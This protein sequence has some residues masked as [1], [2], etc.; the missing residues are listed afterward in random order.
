[1]CLPVWAVDGAVVDLK[2]DAGLHERSH[3]GAVKGI[4]VAGAYLDSP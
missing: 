2:V 3:V 1:M 4:E